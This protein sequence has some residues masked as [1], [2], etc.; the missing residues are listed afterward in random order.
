M[1]QQ[2]N[3]RPETINAFL[4]VSR[5]YLQPSARLDGSSPVTPKHRTRW[6]SLVMLG[7]LGTAL[8]QPV[9]AAAPGREP[10]ERQSRDTHASAA[11]GQPA[12]S[13]PLDKLR[14]P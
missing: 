9:Y 11:A 4:R 2:D 8:G 13:A 14:K 5:R 3:I 1:P 7:T 12:D 10:Q 6:R